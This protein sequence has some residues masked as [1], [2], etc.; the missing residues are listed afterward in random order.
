MNPRSIKRLII[1]VLFLFGVVV[2][3]IALYFVIIPEPT[4]LDG[5]RNQGEK[6]IDCGGPCF[7]CPEQPNLENL[8][9]VSI[10]WV[11]DRD[12]KYDA[13]VKIKN[14]NNLYG[15]NKFDL[16]ITFFSE[17]GQQLKEQKLNSFILPGEEKY[18]LSQGVALNEAPAD[19]KVEIASETWEKFDDYQKPDL[20]IN[21]KRFDILSGGS[22]DY[23]KAWGTLINNSR[24]D[25]ETITIKVVLRDDRGKLLAENSHIMNTVRAKEQRDFF[26]NFPH[27]FAGSVANVEVE[28]EVDVFNSQN[29]IL[30]HGKPEK[31]DER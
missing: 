12:D 5:K 23:A 15:A 21:S 8:S 7:P 26:A 11:Y 17:S 4:C 9:V 27:Q 1:S 25:F 30:I 13:A 6:G 31:W 2:L 16:K 14:P 19:V 3:G 20:I 18:V 24:Y 28:P 29:Y 22:S 10:E